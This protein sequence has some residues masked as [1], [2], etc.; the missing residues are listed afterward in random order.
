MLRLYHLQNL[1]EMCLQIVEILYAH[2]EGLGFNELAKPSGPFN[3][4]TLQNHLKHLIPELVRIRSIKQKGGEKHLH[5]LTTKAVNIVFKNRSEKY[6]RLALSKWAQDWLNDGWEP[7]DVT[8]VIMEAPTEGTV[9]LMRH[10]DKREAQLVVSPFLDASVYLKLTG[11]QPINL[12]PDIFTEIDLALADA[13]TLVSKLIAFIKTK[14]LIEAGL[15]PGPGYKRFLGTLKEYVT[16]MRYAGGPIPFSKEIQQETYTSKGDMKVLLGE[17]I[18]RAIQN[19]LN[20]GIYF[21]LIGDYGFWI[22]LNQKQ[23]SLLATILKNQIKA[24]KFRDN[25]IL[26]LKSFIEKSLNEANK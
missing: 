24:T 7:I 12:I 3:K 15:D 21:A 11:G 18:F 2:P 23:Q 20:S 5:I 26:K 19:P 9:Y 17:S 25:F 4:K 14:R 16:T 8:A 1:D 13:Q 22:V 6:G 10:R